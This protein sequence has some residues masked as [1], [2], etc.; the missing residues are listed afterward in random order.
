M[1]Q[2]IEKETGKK[3]AYSETP[4]LLLVDSETGGLKTCLPDLNIPMYSVSS[5]DEAI[6][7]IS[8]HP[9]LMVLVNLTVFKKTRYRGIAKLSDALQDTG[10]PIILVMSSMDEFES[11][12]GLSGNFYLIPNPPNPDQLTNLISLYTAKHT[13]EKQHK[14]TARLLELSNEELTSFSYAVSHD[15]R[16][17]LRAVT[18]FSNVLLKKA[19]DQLDGDHLRYLNLI[20]DNVEKLNNQID[21]LLTL[22]RLS[23]QDLH[24]EKVD[25][26]YLVRSVFEGLTA[27]LG[28]PSPNLVISDVPKAKVDHDMM[29]LALTHLLDNAIKFSSHQAEPL[30]EFGY[31]RDHDKGHY[32]LR[33]NGI[34]FEEEYHEKLFELFQKLHSEE[35]YPGNGA[36]LAIV[37]RIIMRHQ[38]NV[39]ASGEIGK[40]TTIYFSFPE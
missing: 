29:R 22:S 25:L 9:I 35:E 33:D 37:K 20:V 10:Q 8:K 31:D 27:E 26:P 36:G 30:I 2:L 28:R 40:G 6:N 34:G 12:S 18:G 5:E 14:E 7:E 24:L 23:R 38:G 39:W 19:A 17:P 32:Y 21:D 1:N 3:P 16:A 11:I 13:T 4:G 15:L